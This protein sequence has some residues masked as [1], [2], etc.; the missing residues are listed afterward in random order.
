MCVNC[1][2]KEEEKEEEG[3]ELSLD[4][5]VCVYALC[6]DIIYVLGGGLC[7]SVLDA[8]YWIYYVHIV[9]R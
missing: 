6:L 2:L 5:P 3:V 8:G 7:D 4:Q 9:H 1:K